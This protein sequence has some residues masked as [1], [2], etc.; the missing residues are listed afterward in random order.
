M[1]SIGMHH[2]SCF[3]I[4]F[5]VAVSTDVIS[6]IYHHHLAIEF[7]YQS[8]GDNGTGETRTNY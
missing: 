7:I 8:F 4:S 3:F 5:G 6:F 1:R 2:H